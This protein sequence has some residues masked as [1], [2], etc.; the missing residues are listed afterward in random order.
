MITKKDLFNGLDMIN[1][2]LRNKV[3]IVAVGGTALTL[4]NIKDSTI[5][6]DFCISSGDKDDF[7]EASYG[8]KFRIDLFF[9]GFIFSEQLPS[10]Y[11]ERSR[12]IK[13]WGK[14]ELLALS[15]EDIIITKAARYNQ[16]DEED[17][18]V[19]AQKMDVGK[20]ELEKRFQKVVDTYVGNVE[21]YRIN[22][23]FI[24]KRHFT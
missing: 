14:I 5:D 21:N 6:V 11:I 16:R 1:D 18:K 15:A 2:R 10:D 24:I 20:E 23:E 12:S 3:T 17:I 13:K 9:D 7:I 22:F 4:L 19:I 8:I